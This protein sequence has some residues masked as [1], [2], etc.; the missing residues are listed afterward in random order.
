MR[1]EISS[2]ML[3]PQGVAEQAG[4]RPDIAQAM[5]TNSHIRAYFAGGHVSHAVSQAMARK[6]VSKDTHVPQR[7]FRT[8]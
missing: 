8:P 6:A 4:P 1:G 3:H 2:K 7:P 5:R